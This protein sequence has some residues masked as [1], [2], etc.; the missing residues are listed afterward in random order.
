MGDVAEP[1]GLVAD[2]ALD[3]QRAGVAD[4][5][6]GPDEPADVDLAL[7]ERDLL[8]PASGVGRAAARP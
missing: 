8:A 3:D 6:E 2:L 7:A 4:R 5:L 1:A